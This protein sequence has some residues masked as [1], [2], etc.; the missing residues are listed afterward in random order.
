[1]AD[2]RK[3]AR[4]GKARSG[5]AEQLKRRYEQ[6]ASIRQLA[7]QTGRSYGFVHRVLTE[8][9]VRLRGR[10][11]R[12]T[13]DS[14]RE[15]AHR[16]LDAVPVSRL[17][18]A[19]EVLRRLAEAAADT[20][21]PVRRFRTVGVFDGEPDLGRRAKELARREIGQKPSKTA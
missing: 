16:L 2:A 14:T 11:S 17:P 5:L 6:G 21:R 19:A 12:Q 3:G 7:E 8:T 10:G 20:R 4:I 9:G 1:M 13:R 18:E 15:Q